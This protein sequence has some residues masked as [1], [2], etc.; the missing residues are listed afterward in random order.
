ME[1]RSIGTWNIAPVGYGCMG[2]SHAHGYA[3]EF[4]DGVACVRDA[5]EA[6]YTYF[7]TATTYTGVT[8]S[9][10]PAVNEEVV[11]AALAPVRDQVVVATKF[12]VRIN[13]DHSLTF[14]SSEANIRATVE[15]SLRQLGFDHLDLVYQARIDPAQE[16][17]AV[18]EVAG[19]L[20]KEGKILAWGISEVPEDY[21]RRAHAVTPVTAIQNKINMAAREWESMFAVC[22][23]LGVAYTVFSPLMK[24]FFSGRPDPG[25]MFRE[26][27]DYRRMIP[28]FSERGIAQAEPLYDMLDE[29]SEAHGCTW[30]QLSLAWLLAKRPYIVPVPGSTNPGRLR[31]NLAAA[32]IKL[33]PEEV[34]AID[35]RLDEIKPE[36]FGAE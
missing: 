3:M 19:Q 21:L 9:G 24:G 13:E 29:Y 20:I 7:D 10:K 2:I 26:G 27:D 30:T 32:E 16:P 1:T 31:E 6:G 14:D 18:A 34:A 23:E 5:F 28:Q 17:E 12:G 8:R 11:G 15:K 33:T 35:A 22:D 4:S 25:H 36:T